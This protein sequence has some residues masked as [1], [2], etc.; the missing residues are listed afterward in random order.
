MRR[1]YSRWPTLL[2][3]TRRICNGITPTLSTP[4]LPSPIFA[5]IRY[6]LSFRIGLL[7]TCA[8]NAKNHILVEK[9]SVPLLP[10]KILTQKNWYLL[11]PSLPLYLLRTFSCLSTLF[12]PSPSPS[13]S[14]SPSLSFFVFSLFTRYAVGAHR[15]LRNRTAPNTE[16]IIWSTSVGTAVV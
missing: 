4:S 1:Y 3:Q 7:I 8:T 5:I 13:S 16:E 6:L 2:Q 11:H 10:P 12:P 9:S 15:E 14:L